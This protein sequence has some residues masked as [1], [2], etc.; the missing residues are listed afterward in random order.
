[1]ILRKV[2]VQLLIHRLHEKRV[3]LLNRSTRFCVWTCWTGPHASRA[4]YVLLSWLSECRLPLCIRINKVS[5]YIFRRRVISL[6]ACNSTTELSLVAVIVVRKYVFSLLVVENDLSAVAL[7]PGMT[8]NKQTSLSTSPRSSKVDMC[9][10][11]V[12]YGYF[13]R[14]DFGKST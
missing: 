6:C 12:H 9:K 11:H 8:R 2:L 7:L 3:D 4:V 14:V 5:D 1:M 10:N 13:L